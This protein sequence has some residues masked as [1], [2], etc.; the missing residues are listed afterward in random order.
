MTEQNQPTPKAQLRALST[1]YFLDAL[2]INSNQSPVDVEAILH[3]RGY[4]IGSAKFGEDDIYAL[5][6]TTLSKNEKEELVEVVTPVIQV[7]MDAILRELKRVDDANRDLFGTI[8]TTEPTNNECSI[9][10]VNNKCSA[11]S[12]N[13]CIIDGVNY[14]EDV[15][16][17]E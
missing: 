14:S 6:F 9:G 1:N 3:H 11:N 8:E 10:S 4:R 17:T 2:D 7:N 15:G 16:A 12:D 13:E 5:G